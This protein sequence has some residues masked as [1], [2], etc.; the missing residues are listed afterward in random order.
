MHL[1]NWRYVDDATGTYRDSD[2]SDASY[3]YAL[4]DLKVGDMP[5]ASL[6]LGVTASPVDDSKIQLL[7]RYYASTTLIGIL[8]QENIPMIHH[9]IEIKAGGRLSMA[10]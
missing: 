8:L 2:G 6:A 4:K 9:L 1:G 3:S 5:Q 7:Y 10:F